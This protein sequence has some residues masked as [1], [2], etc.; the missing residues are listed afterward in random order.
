MADQISDFSQY[1]A[2]VVDDFSAMRSMLAEMLRSYG[3]RNIDMAANGKEACGY[4]S[5]RQYDIVLCDFN[6]GAG[7][8]GQQILEEAKFR[9]WIGPMCAWIMITAE[10]TPDSVHGAVEY[11]P[12]GYLIKPVN[13]ALLFQRLGRIL[14]RKSAFAEINTKLKRNDYRGA[15]AMCDARIEQEKSNAGELLRWKSQMLMSIGELEQARELFEKVLNERDVAWA[16]VGLAEVKQREGDFE[17]S[18]RL[19]RQVI[20]DLPAHVK[21]YDLLA[22]GLEKLGLLEEARATLENAARL[23]PNSPVRQKN[24]GELALRC[25]DVETAEAAFRKSMAV[26]ENSV[27]KTPDSYI[28]LARIMGNRQQTEEASR[29]LNKLP[30]TFEDTAV[31]LRAKAVEGMIYQ[32]NGQDKEAE[33]VAADLSGMMKNAAMHADTAANLEAAELFFSTGRKDDAIALLSDVVR[34]NPEDQALMGRVSLAYSN[35]GLTEEGQIWM[36]QAR[37]DATAQ[38]NEGV[39]L[40]RDGKLPEAVA[41]MRRAVAAMPSNVRVLLNCGHVMLLSLQKR[42]DP[43]LKR[44]ALE[45]LL[46]ANSLLPGDKRCTR[47]LNQ[48]EAMD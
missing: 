12:D 17:G 3:A 25:G 37:D 10:Q 13:A 18:C 35:A 24:M 23:S 8:N 40:A 30:Q 21:A 19:L 45:V 47:L 43:S 27:L 6:L 16:R 29:L 39:L 15:I 2:L 48:L 14:A 38:M 11:Q 1:R 26:G 31:H 22:L 5:V 42:N 32:R 4:L 34:N 20:A 9:N 33:R 28:G 44:E 41:S 36:K 7:K 46:T